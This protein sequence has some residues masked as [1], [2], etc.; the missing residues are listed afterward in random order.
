MSPLCV[1]N[2]YSFLLKCYY[3]CN[4][5]PLHVHLGPPQHKSSPVNVATSPAAVQQSSSAIAQQ[6]QLGKL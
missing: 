1:Y 4:Q 5:Q 6:I 2:N 3:L